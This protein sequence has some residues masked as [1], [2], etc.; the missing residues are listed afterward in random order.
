MPTGTAVTTSNAEA[1]VFV[2]D[3]DAAVRDSLALLLRSVGLASET[4]ASAD[5]F[6]AAFDPA[7]PGCLVLDVRMPGMSGLELQARLHER[8]ASLPIVFLTAHGDVD[9]AVQ[10][11]K[12]GA[13]DFV[14]KPFRDQELL[15]KLQAALAQDARLR[16]ERTDADDIRSRIASLTPRELQLLEMVVAGKA[17]KEIAQDLGISQRTVEIHRAHVMKK[18]KADAVTDLVR[19]VMRSHP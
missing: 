4:Y 14:Q 19:L 12:A 3:D 7:R 11:V 8:R 6:L 1:T 5:E 10:A 15:D 17:N 2:V 16:P 18:M 13:F 9:M